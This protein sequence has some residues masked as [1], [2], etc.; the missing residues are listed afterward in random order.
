[1]M[2][3]RPTIIRKSY[4]NRTFSAPYSKSIHCNVECDAKLSSRGIADVPVYVC[5]CVPVYVCVCVCGCG[6]I[7]RQANVPVCVCGSAGIKSWPIG[8]F[9][10]V[11][12]KIKVLVTVEQSD[13]RRMM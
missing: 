1:M 5:V 11:R 13:R 10:P 9:L 2:I 12:W 6:G 7:P 8:F 3:P 4:N